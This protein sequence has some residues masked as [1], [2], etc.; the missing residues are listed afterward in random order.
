MRTQGNT[1]CSEIFTV[2]MIRLGESVFSTEEGAWRMPF[3]ISGIITLVVAFG[4][5]RFFRSQRG[6]YEYRPAYLPALREL[7]KYSVVFLVAI[8]AVFFAADQVGLPEW[9]VAVLIT[10]IALSL[11]G[12]VFGRKGGEVGPVLYDRDL[13][14]IYIAA[15]AYLWNLWFFSFWSVSIV[16]QAAGGESLLRAGLTA[17]FNAGAGILG[18]PI[19]GWLA[20]YAK[21]RRW[22]RKGILVSFTLITG[23]LTVAF[24]LYI[25]NGGQSLS[26]MGI[27]LFFQALFFFALQPVSHALTADLVNNPALLGAAFGMWNLIAEIGAVLSPAISG[28]LRGATGE[29][30]VAVM[31]DAGVILASIV[32]LLF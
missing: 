13:L 25:I 31:L 4:I 1:P 10:L 2:P 19:G 9:V 3:F 28:V 27:L 23:L 6:Q 17:A 30:H 24:G 15:I 11:V 21:R 7:G 16:N 14:L 32:V 22:G 20:D 29:W 12:F 5:V 26:V 8:M 18:F